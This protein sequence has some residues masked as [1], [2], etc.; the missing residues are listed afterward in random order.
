[1]SQ[2]WMRVS[3]KPMHVQNRWWWCSWFD[4]RASA[5][6]LLGWGNWAVQLDCPREKGFPVVFCGTSWW[7][8]SARRCSCVWPE[9]HGE[10]DS[11]YPCWSA[12]CI[13]SSSLTP[14][15]DNQTSPPRTEPAFLMSL[16]IL[17]ASIEL[18][19]VPQYTMAKTI[20]PAYKD[21]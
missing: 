9:Q 21:W 2:S 14:P 13:A 16:L 4:F 1:M 8:Q 18:T 20:A 17:L 10:D 3:E 5:V 7:Y 12:I 15:P 6:P 11:P 19:L